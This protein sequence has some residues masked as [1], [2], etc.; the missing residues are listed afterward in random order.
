MVY[1]MNEGR[2]LNQPSSYYYSIILEGYKS[3]G[4]DIE[5]LKN[6]FNISFEL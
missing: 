4:F 1:I 3:A 2:P 6:V 5:N